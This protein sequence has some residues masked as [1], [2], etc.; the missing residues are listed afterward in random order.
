MRIFILIL[1]SLIHSH[2]LHAGYPT[3][4][5]FGATG[6]IAGFSSVRDYRTGNFHCAYIDRTAGR[7]VYK[8]VKPDGSV[9]ISPVTEQVAV[10][11]EPN[12]SF[13]CT[14]IAFDSNSR[15]VIAFTRF[16]GSFRSIEVSR[17]T[18]AAWLQTQVVGGG[19]ISNKLSLAL[20]NEVPT[21]WRL[22]YVDYLEP[23]LRIA[24]A[25][26]VNFKIAD[27]TASP[28]LAGVD[29]YYSA[30]SGSV[31]FQDPQGGGLKFANLSDNGTNA[32]A[33][34][35]LDSVDQTSGAGAEVFHT[36]GPGGWPH[37]VYLDQNSG[38]VKM[39][40]RLPG[41]SW[42]SES[43]ILRPFPA[44]VLANPTLAFDNDE[45]P[46]IACT[47]SA[48]DTVRIAARVGGTWYGD[49]INEPSLFRKPLFLS[50]QTTGG[51]RVFAVA[52]SSI[53]SASNLRYYGPIDDFVDADAD[54]VPLRFER[55]F[56]MN[57]T[58][59]D[60]EKLPTPS[61]I[62]RN[63]QPRFVLNMRLQ[64]EGT[65]T[66]GHLYETADY[67]VRVEASANLGT[68]I[69]NNSEIGLDDAFTLRGVRYFTPY[70]LDPVGSNGG[71][72]FFRVRVDRK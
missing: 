61:I 54:A 31:A 45:N 20:N 1:I 27:F 60:R 53:I 52:D 11:Q 56:M 4:V 34:I 59:P 66:G 55:V 58:V 30:N 17:W 51:I 62:T 37:F 42:T 49:V 25:G 46:M 38:A 9:Q 65:A 18:G 7:V 69:N 64:P 36:A 3:A 35:N 13:A 16:D 44:T 39:A 22:A 2:L 72:R 15:P 68:W 32:V 21:A 57:P 43:V 14:S 33:I 71:T 70:A 47:S 29:L 28:I 6:P 26:G 41:F 12:P 23:S 5:V 19:V 10:T 8:L 63:G 24:S 67:R 48:G 40:R 50:P